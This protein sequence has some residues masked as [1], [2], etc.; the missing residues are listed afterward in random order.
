VRLL[1]SLFFKCKY[2]EI[3]ALGGVYFDILAYMAATQSL[4]LCYAI[5]IPLLSALLSYGTNKTL[6]NGTPS[7]PIDPIFNIAR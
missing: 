3:S 6:N 7:P 2:K 4:L 5:K 1:C